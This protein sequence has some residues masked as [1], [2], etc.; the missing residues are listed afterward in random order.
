MRLSTGLASALALMLSSPAAAQE[1]RIGE[2]GF[3]SPPATLE[4]VDWLVGQWAGTGIQG[5]PAIESWLPPVGGTMVGTFVQDTGEGGI[6]FTEHM[7][8]TEQDGSLVMKLKHFNADLTSWEDKDGM[9]TFRLLA[10]EDCAAYFHGLTLRCRNPSFPD[11]GLLVAVR[12]QS[13]GELVF[14]FEALGREHP[15]RC[16]DAITTIDMDQCY[17]DVLGRAD[18][19]REAYLAKAVERHADRPELGKEI[20]ASDAAF[21]AYRDAE[22][23]AVYEDWKEGTIRGVMGLACRIDMTDRR[24][25]TI[26]RNWLTYMDSTPPALPEPKPTL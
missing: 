14:R 8:L 9:V 7:Y 16:T 15:Q 1:T 5:A 23:G 11:E 22:C 10:V 20:E 26:W 4:Q 25:L 18:E 6:M 19:R 3:E 2:E 17:A 12:M 13:G 21:L 24:T